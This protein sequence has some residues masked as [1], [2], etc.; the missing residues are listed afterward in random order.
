[1]HFS[2]QVLAL[3]SI[4]LI[5]Q[6]VGED[7]SANQY[8]K[9]K[10][11]TIQM[12]QVQ[13]QFLPKQAVFGIGG[14]E[15]KLVFQN[16]RYIIPMATDRVD[17]K[18]PGDEYIQY[19]NLYDGIDLVFSIDQGKLKSSYIVRNEETLKKLAISYE[20]APKLESNAKQL[21]VG[22]LWVE[23][24]LALT[25][26]QGNLLNTEVTMKLDGSIVSYQTD[27]KAPFVL[28]PTYSFLIFSTYLGAY[29]ADVSMGVVVDSQDNSY[30]AGYTDSPHFPKV[31]AYDDTFNGKRDAFIASFDPTGELRWSTVF[32]GSEVDAAYAIAI[33]NNEN[34]YITGDTVSE[35]FPTHNGF[36]SNFSGRV[37]G[38]VASFTPNGTLRW[39]TYLGGITFDS[40]RGIAVDGDNNVYVTGYTY[41]D[42]FPTRNAFNYTFGYVRD[43]FVTSFTS[44]GTM[45]WST[46]LG[47]RYEDEG[48][49]IDVDAEGSVYVTGLTTSPNFPIRRPMQ[50]ILAGETD[51]FLAKFS[52]SGDL[53]WS[54]FIGGAEEDMG[55]AVATHAN[56]GVFLTCTS[57]SID[58]PMQNAYQPE[59]KGKNDMVILRFN[60]TGDLQWSTYF[61]GA[62]EEFAGGMDVDFFGNVYVVGATNSSDFPRWLAFDEETLYGNYDVALF[63]FSY[64]G[65]LKWS[66]TLGEDYSY[67]GNAVALDSAENVYLT[68]EAVGGGFPLKNQYQG[69]TGINDIILS[70]LYNPLADSDQDGMPNYFEYTYDL[71]LESNDTA[72]DRDGDGLTN[73]QEYQL[74][75]NPRSPDTDQ[76]GMPDLY[77]YQNGLNP[78]VDDAD[79][80]ID[81]DGISNLDE[82]KLSTKQIETSSSTPPRTPILDLPA[83][84]ISIA[85]LFIPKKSRKTLK[86]LCKQ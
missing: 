64:S 17:A 15:V 62:G 54:T 48:H 60:E 59:L 5:L 80:D 16:A 86:K 8:L 33:D 72:L 61:G 70:R 2:S 63:S 83:P 14:K 35:D 66:S 50:S 27:A 53:A 65:T 71:D 52:N 12:G 49:G 42:D 6:T 13:I 43:A 39:S 55:K 28:D 76:D 41:S 23:D 84:H 18:I 36:N 68:G 7:P 20:G 74:G 11:I 77:E 24:N 19:R 31:N 57:K 44:N 51:A 67:T 26:I 81:G 45:R 1:M 82:Y 73:Y 75:T 79:G 25:D 47:G 3:I 9:P 21:Q 56:I 38:F 30:I 46:F 22:H 29:D 58:F 85:I 40:S 37:D 4:L 69:P 10:E 34:L 32:G 78:L